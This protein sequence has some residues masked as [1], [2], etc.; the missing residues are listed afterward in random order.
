MCFV[1]QFL[2]KVPEKGLPKDRLHVVRSA[3]LRAT[4]LAYQSRIFVVHGKKDTPTCIVSHRSLYNGGRLL[5]WGESKD[6]RDFKETLAKAVSVSRAELEKRIEKNKG[7]KMAKHK[8]FRY[9]PAKAA[10]SR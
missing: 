2:R 4:L 3:G 6:V 9:L 5:T 10:A 1:D 7:E 8:R